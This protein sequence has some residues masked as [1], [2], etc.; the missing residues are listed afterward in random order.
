MQ[1]ESSHLQVHVAKR[2]DDERQQ[3]ERV[4][5]LSVQRAKQC[6]V[7]CE[8]EHVYMSQTEKKLKSRILVSN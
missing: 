6:L 7:K 3:I 4:R 2:P 1:R 5:S 8:Q